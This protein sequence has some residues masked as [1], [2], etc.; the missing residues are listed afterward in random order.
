MTGFIMDRLA[1]MEKDKSIQNLYGIIV[2]SGTERVAAEFLRDGETVSWTYADYDRMARA[3]AAH[4]RR[5]FWQ[6]ESSVIAIKA[7]TCPEWP[8]VFWGVLMAGFSPLL[9]DS[10]L[11]D[12]M[13]AYLLGQAGASGIVNR[14]GAEALTDR[15]RQIAF[16]DL[17][18]APEA[19]ENFTP[20]FSGF[21]ALCTSGTTATAR[22]FVYNGEALVNQT[23][24]S[25]LI[26]R[27]TRYIVNDEPRRTLVFLPL[28]H[29]LGFMVNILWA[30]FLGYASIFMKDRSPQTVVETCN[31]LRVEIVI[32]V[33]LLINNLSVA[34]CKKVAK[35]P[36]GRRAAF[37]AMKWL[38]LAAQTVAPHAGLRFARHLLFKDVVK[39]LLGPDI[40]CI[41]LGGSHTPAEHMRTISA[42]GYYTVC[43]FGMTETAVTSVETTMNVHKRIT[44]SVGTPMKSAEY[45]VLPI[46]R[47]SHSRGEMLVRGGTLHTGRL[48]DGELAP[49]D[50]DERG[51]YPTGDIVRLRRDGMWV[52]GRSKD[53]IINES[54]ENVYPDELEDMFSNLE[55]V[56]QFCAL[57]IAREGD[58]SGRYQDIVLVCN[59]GAAYNDLR[60]LETLIR[61]IAQ[62]NG[63]LPV[64]KRLT[65]VIVTPEKLPVV[66]AIK[67]K[68][69]TLREQLEKRKIAHRDLDLRAGAVRAPK[70]PATEP[71][72]S[73]EAAPVD[74][75]L[76]E[77]RTRVRGVFAEVLEAEPD[78]VRDDAHFVDDLG[79]DSLQSL[80]IAL[81][82]EEI[83]GILIPTERYAECTNVADLSALVYAHMRGDVPYA[84][85][86]A[87]P[88]GEAKPIVR[89]EDTSEYH[90]FEA[91]KAGLAEYGNPYFVCHESPLSD[92]STMDGHEVLNFG[93]Y[94]YAGMS[95]RRE[96]MDAAEAAI[97][98]YGTSASGSRLLAGE[99]LLHQELEREIAEWKH[100][101]AA[102]VLVGGHSTNVT[103]V[104]NF[105]GPRDL[106][107][108]DALA[109]NSVEQGCRLS[110]ATAKPFP[111]ND[112]KALESIL[113]TQR[114]RFEKVL[115][116]V[117]GAYSMD[118]DIAPIPE[119]VRVKKEF[120]CFLMVDEAHSACVIGRS[121]G[122]VDEYF[123]LGPG[124]IDIKMGTLSK[125]LGACG[126]Y[127]AGSAALIEYL[128]YAL[129]GFVFSVGISPPL[130]AATLR[131]IRLLREDPSI[132]ERLHN[133]I[134]SFID[135][136]SKRNLD[137]CLAG[138]TA[139]V[140]ILVG[141]DEDAF[142]LS[143]LLRQQ[144]VFVPPAVYPAVP[145]NKA[146]LRFC[147]ISEHKREQMVQALDI[148][149]RMAAE[150]GIQ[151]PRRDSETKMQDPDKKREVTR[152]TQNA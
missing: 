57:G 30:Q 26:M 78:S 52:E 19:P 135:E 114:K 152:K 98:K 79:G 36:R 38:S 12:E 69:I 29:V 144:G 4:I 141:R 35:E 73:Q 148:L 51:W 75:Q 2:S 13:T 5:A 125:G 142:A 47:W 81:K 84:S 32:A 117:E 124:D 48:I 112:H 111:H 104:G 74:L 120:G 103:F 116:I 44:G 25:G 149:E 129:P 16:A 140:P 70:A 100:S 14:T 138:E 82:V 68:R 122:G 118:G 72:V 31:R 146:R 80:G 41:I 23:L 46:S 102:L 147:V 151:L 106:I 136:A 150:H 91:R 40:R 62:A 10:T 54:G 45:H 43:G 113:R 42:L 15:Y 65:R 115:I 37:A 108:Y 95:G 21:V 127:L 49:P 134:H 105:C 130:A 77:I 17:L 28:H 99:K 33:P 61:A 139:I 96:V 11:S 123:A 93:S 59:V 131:A 92:V 1:R 76:D 22:I 119:F 56:E 86:T 6:S 145:K 88:A 64:F 71:V 110:P 55:G 89:F 8:A 34:L 126:G 85:E 143:T 137:T 97:E 3:Y 63:R 39:Q 9:L 50:V 121:G 53:V 109:H 24:N 67:V 94:N 107:V 87:L 132:M 66:N 90:A 18:A 60:Y 7:D 27:A 58:K 83:F 20:R 133:N 101:E 128:R